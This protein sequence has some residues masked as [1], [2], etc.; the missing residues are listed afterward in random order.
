MLKMD[1]YA[2]LILLVDVY[3]I[4]NLIFNIITYFSNNENIPHLYR[5]H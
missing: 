4:I 3:K 1:V 2:K 5:I